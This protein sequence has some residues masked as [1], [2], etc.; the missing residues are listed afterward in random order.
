MPYTLAARITGKPRTGDDADLV[1]QSAEKK[2][3]KSDAKAD[4]KGEPA[5]KK[6]GIDVI[7]VAD[8]DMLLSDFFNL[9]AH[10]TSESDEFDVD[11]VTFVLNVLDVLANDNRF[12]D[13][14]SAAR[15]IAR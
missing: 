11:N 15:S 9:R 8:V 14:R 5:G 13:L 7:L 1:T 4:K 6:D 2:D 3:E 10:R 12:V